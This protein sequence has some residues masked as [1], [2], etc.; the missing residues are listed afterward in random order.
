MRHCKVGSTGSNICTLLALIVLA[1][2]KACNENVTDG[3]SSD[4]VSGPRAMMR[5][6]ASGG[7][8]F[9]VRGTRSESRRRDTGDSESRGPAIQPHVPQ[10]RKHLAVYRKCLTKE[11]AV[12]LDLVTD[13]DFSWFL[14]FLITGRHSTDMCNT[15]DGGK[16]ISA[17]P[18]R[19]VFFENMSQTVL[20]NLSTGGL[21][22]VTKL[23]PWS[24]ERFAALFTVFT[25]NV[26]PVCHPLLYKAP[27]F[28][29][30]NEARGCLFVLLFWW[31]NAPWQAARVVVIVV[32]KWTPRFRVRFHF[33][34]F[35]QIQAHLC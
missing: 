19:H 22:S 34:S 25:I 20:Q 24:Q 11:C 31:L 10:Q 17:F 4:F 26:F 29:N 33:Q 21:S 23:A 27:H 28:W 15:D 9:Y 1:W 7:L 13:D 2:S 5:A 14:S 32:Q 6:R 30:A 16:G 12:C 35:H 3:V 18:L 8:P